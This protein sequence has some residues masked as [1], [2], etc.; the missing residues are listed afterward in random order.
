MGYKNFSEICPIFNT[1]NDSGLEHEF[2][3]P[4]VRGSCTVS[5]LATFAHQFGREV[6]VQEIFA[7]SYQSTTCCVFLSCSQTLGIYKTSITT[8]LHGDLSTAA[9]IGS[10]SYG[11]VEMSVVGDCIVAASMT[12][13]AFGSTDT[14]LL[15]NISFADLGRIVTDQA[16][17]QIVIRYRDK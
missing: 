9:V 5:T 15:S 2:A 11:S 4:Y 3:F 12:S 7:H 1:D 10:L 6:I 16:H 17:P 8:R 13:T 14:L